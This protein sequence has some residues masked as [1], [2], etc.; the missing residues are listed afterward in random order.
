[1]RGFNSD[2]ANFARWIVR[3]TEEKTKPSESRLREYR[4]SALS[5]LEQE[6]FSTAPIYKSLETVTLADSLAQMR[7]A[8]GADNPVVQ[9]SANGKSPEDA[10]KDLIANTKL[11]EVSV[12]KQ[13]YEGGRPRCRP[14]RSSH[15]ADAQHRSAMPATPQKVR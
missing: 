7:D 6:L 13:L 10:A 12:R 15:R 4:D 11:D 2:L 9:Q 5:S 14:P 8:L 1:M 3:A